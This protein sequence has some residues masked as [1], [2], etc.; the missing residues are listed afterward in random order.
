MVFVIPVEGR[1]LFGHLH[2]IMTTLPADVKSAC[3]DRGCYVSG[4]IHGLV[5]TVRVTDAVLFERWSC[6]QSLFVFGVSFL[7]VQ[8]LQAAV[9]AAPCA[10]PWRQQKDCD[11]SRS[12]CNAG[13]IL[14]VGS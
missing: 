4:Q 6:I 14:M 8:C 10:R 1:K 13:H 2:V 11:Q 5:V 3:W 9:V 12:S 7:T